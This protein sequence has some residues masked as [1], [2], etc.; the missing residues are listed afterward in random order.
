MSVDLPPEAAPEEADPL[1]RFR[2]WRGFLAAAIGVNVL[3]VY[4]MFG[5][6]AEGALAIWYKTLIWLPFNVIASVL[7]YVFKVKLADQPG[8]AL[9]G[10]LCLTMVAANWIVMFIV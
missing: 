8:G 1:V 3:F 6:Q 2:N 9:F 5:H 10:A 4:G 7:Y